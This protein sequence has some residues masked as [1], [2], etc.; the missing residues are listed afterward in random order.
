MAVCLPGPCLLDGQGFTEQAA[1]PG[2][3]I[4]ENIEQIER[5]RGFWEKPT[6]MVWVVWP[7]KLRGLAV[8]RCPLKKGS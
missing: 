1:T 5:A 7:D 6:G 3:R 8:R 4:G 2:G